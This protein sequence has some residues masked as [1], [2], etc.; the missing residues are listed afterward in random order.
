MHCRVRGAYVI[1]PGVVYPLL[2]KSL[3]L[4]LSLLACVHHAAAQSSDELLKAELVPETT[5]I[6]AGKPFT[7]A[8][9][10]KHIEHGHTYWKNPGGPGMGTKF[11]WTLPEGFTA[12]EPQWPAPIHGKFES[13]TV[14]TYEGEVAP[15]V[16]ITPPASL[17]A[18]DAVAL[19][20]SINALVCVDVC[21]PVR[22]L[23]AKASVTVADAPGASEAST[24]ALFAKARAA[25]PVEPKGWTITA[26]QKD[27]AFAIVLQPG[28][29]ANAKLAKAYFFSGAYP[30]QDID[31][32]K[33]QE[34]KKD[35]D[36]WVL[37]LPPT[38]DNPPKEALEGLLVSE[39]GWLDGDAT[40]KAF[41]VKLPI[42]PAGAASAPAAPASTPTS[43]SATTAAIAPAQ[44][45]SV[46]TLLLFA[47]IGGLILNVM[48]C[49]FPVLGIKIL[50]F[51]QQAGNDRKKIF[52]HGVAYTLGV[53]VCFWVLA[54]F[55]ITL[56]KGWGAQLQS[57]L[58]VL[59]LC[60]FFMAFGLNMAGVFEI[61]T[62]AVGVGQE[63]QNKS[64]LRG[65]FFSG[66]LATVVA[67]PCSAPFL[68]TALTYAVSLPTML[69]LGVFTVI[70]LG[71]SAP[72]LILSLAP[73]LVKKLPRPGAWM[74]S[75]KQGMSFLIFGTVGYMLW[76]LGGLVDEWHL[77]MTIFGLVLVSL[78][79]WIYGRWYLP[80]KSAKARTMGLGFAILAL[81]SGL[82][83]GWPQTAPAKGSAQ[84][85]T[86]QVWSPELVK[87]LRD[88]GKPVYIDFTAR[89]CAT[90]QVNK[91]IYH[92][93]SVQ[94]LIHDKG[95]QLLKADWTNYDDRITQVLRDEYKKAAVPVNVYF[96]PGA[97]DPV[98]LPEL[99]SAA[100]FKDAILGTHTIE[101]W[102]LAL[103][104]GGAFVILIV[105][106]ARRREG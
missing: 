64:G 13:F 49:V 57:P 99:L 54:L 105:V 28:A 19:E 22:G 31:S 7:V 84:D 90:C 74:E 87:Q 78:A 1:V 25:L 30:D 85:I 50:G 53:L 60:Y 45:Y 35:G 34:L 65:S 18:G 32:Q 40:T 102:W 39:D 62:S 44:Q 86:W 16:T 17:K 23:I 71:L 55:V 67:T 26:E 92:D 37:N 51:V 10:L 79:C 82:Y 66:L 101:S 20:V 52:L 36:R 73:G 70:G 96:A 42:Q 93:A 75:F 56:G 104:G 46:G 48:P 8:V 58:F 5:T 97:K 24:A 3:L 98:I 27:K 91:R 76:T 21:T 83:L 61:G 63:L 69:A 47:F 38:E 4:G 81:A 59:A 103:A 41:A 100:T 15:L 88:A 80:H 12:G 106:I 95:I 9:K 14:Y 29:G 77:L 11:K 2:M 89:W 94:Q 43:T 33:P 72:Y 68:G 6:A